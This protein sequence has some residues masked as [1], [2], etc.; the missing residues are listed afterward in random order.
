MAASGLP[1]DGLP[2]LP[3]LSG[4]MPLT[5]QDFMYGLQMPLQP[6]SPVY[7]RP[8]SPM[9]GGMGGNATWNN[10]N[11]RRQPSR[12]GPTHQGDSA[13]HFVHPWLHS[14]PSK[15]PAVLSLFDQFLVEMQ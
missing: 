13:P 3:Q 8:G 7:F 2:L 6:G 12:L 4:L 5:T 9:M 11:L 10:L 15:R 14:T 1:T